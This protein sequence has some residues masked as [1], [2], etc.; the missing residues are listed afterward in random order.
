MKYKGD[1]IFVAG[2][3]VGLKSV[4]SKEF[5]DTDEVNK[6]IDGFFVEFDGDSNDNENSI[7]HRDG[8][9]MLKI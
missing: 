2:A 4:L 8:K 6:I 3:K 5:K 1:N 7:L 9:Y